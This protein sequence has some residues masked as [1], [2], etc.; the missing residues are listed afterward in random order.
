[1]DQPWTLVI[2]DVLFDE[3]THHLFRDDDDEH[4]AVIAAGV[5]TTDRGTRLLAGTLSCT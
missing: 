3:L 4:G 2:D 5:A 1:M